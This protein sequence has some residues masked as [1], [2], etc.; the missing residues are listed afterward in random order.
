VALGQGDRDLSGGA[1]VQLG[2]APRAGTAPP[3]QPPVLGVEQ[4]FVDQLVQMELDGVPRQAGACGG[5]VP[6]DRFGLGDDVEVHRPPGRFGEC[7]DATD[8]RDE[9]VHAPS[10]F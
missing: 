5:L 8:L 9:V 4:P 10:P 6:A 2:R 3:G 1:S 7:A